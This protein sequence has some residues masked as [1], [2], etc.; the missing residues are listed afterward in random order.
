MNPDCYGIGYN[1]FDEAVGCHITTYPNCDGAR[2]VEEL[3]KVFNDLH[4]VLT[5]K[6]FK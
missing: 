2:L 4:A 5:G 1:I 3:S 6:S